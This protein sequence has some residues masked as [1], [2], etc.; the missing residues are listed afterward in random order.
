MND[1]PHAR[2]LILSVEQRLAL[3]AMVD[4]LK[5]TTSADTRDARRARRDVLVAHFDLLLEIAKRVLLFQRH[6]EEAMIVHDHREPHLVKDYDADDKPDAWIT[7]L[8]K[9]W[10]LA[11][12]RLEAIENG[13]GTV[14]MDWRTEVWAA[15]AATAK[16]MAIEHM[17]RHFANL[18][19]ELLTGE[20]GDT[21]R[22][23]SYQVVRASDVGD[24]VKDFVQEIS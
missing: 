1:R 20:T 22:R 12:G 13:V 11:G 10:W 5:H 15:V 17:R 3:Q 2:A 6:A 24:A 18:P 8:C 19:T 4:R 9:S 16:T 7:G 21:R 14:D 23:Y